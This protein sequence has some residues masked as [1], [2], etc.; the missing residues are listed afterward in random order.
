PVGVTV[1]GKG[2]NVKYRAARG[3]PVD[4]ACASCGSAQEL[5]GPCWLGPLHNRAFVQRM[6][7]SVSA[8]GAGVY[9][10]QPRM[11]G[12]LKVILEELSDVPLHYSLSKLCTAVRMSCPPLVK[13]NSALLNAGYRVS[14]SHTAQ[15]SIKTDAPPAVVWDIVRTLVAEAGRSSRIQPESPADRILAKDI[16]TPVSF[17]MH[18][19]ANP[20]SRR[21][22]LV[23]YQINPEKNWG[24]KARHTEAPKKQPPP[25]AAAKRDAAT[26]AGIDADADNK[27]PKTD[28]A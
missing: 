5:G 6:Y 17:D 9:G 27:K 16:T 23:R 25:P 12:M 19:D 11:R 10:T 8:A 1:P 24:P 3:P 13:V 14:G 4:Q 20:E 7:D 15:G 22:S 2:A 21:I 26:D 28:D 18:K